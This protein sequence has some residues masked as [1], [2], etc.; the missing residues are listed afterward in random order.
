MLQP[1]RFD[2]IPSN[3]QTQPLLASLS[4]S[5]CNSLSLFTWNCLSSWL[6]AHS[7][8]SSS[9]GV[10][11]WIV[12]EWE[13]TEVSNNWITVT[14]G[15]ANTTPGCFYLLLLGLQ[16]QMTGPYNLPF[17]KASKAASLIGSRQHC[18]AACPKPW[19]YSGS[20]FE[21][22]MA[23]VPV[24]HEL[25]CWQ[26]QHLAWKQL[27]QPP[28]WQKSCLHSAWLL[29]QPAAVKYIANNPLWSCVIWCVNTTVG[30]RAQFYAM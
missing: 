19:A 23:V 3:Y 20:C 21:A 27:Q 7:W 13:F 29:R 14:E 1:N 28:D 8:H 18:I 4:V 12:C 6:M 11:R 9:M 25:T 15:T 22:T 30:I 10:L 24:K 2:T 5:P 26:G 16:V 17:C